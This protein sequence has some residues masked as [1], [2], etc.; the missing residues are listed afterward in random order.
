MRDVV[1]QI[2]EAVTAWAVGRPEIRGVA[3][4][5]SHAR[6]TAGPDSDVDLVIVTERPREL[7]QETD[8]T[9]AFGAVDRIQEEAWGRVTSGSCCARRSRASVCSDAWRRKIV[10]SI[11]FEC[12]CGKCWPWPS[13]PSSPRLRA[14]RSSRA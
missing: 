7:V 2:L 5:G 4:V 3:L 13:I 10:R 1:E 12:G 8:W 14:E 11:G 6:G 9:G